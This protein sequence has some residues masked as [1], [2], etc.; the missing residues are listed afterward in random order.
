MWFE[1][2]RITTGAML[3][4]HGT[5]RRM[6]RCVLA[7]EHILV[8]KVRTIIGTSKITFQHTLAD[9]AIELSAAVLN[10]RQLIRTLR[11][12]TRVHR[13]KHEGIFRR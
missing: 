7:L 2:V 9:I 1:S 13:K 4:S 10:T 3:D 5:R 8:L 11:R 6:W 12:Y